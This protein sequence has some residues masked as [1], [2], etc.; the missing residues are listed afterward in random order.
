MI[1]KFPLLFILCYF[2]TACTL[3]PPDNILPVN[4]FEPDRYMGKWYEIARLD[5]SF[6]QGLSDVSAHYQLLPNGDVEVINSGYDVNKKE[7]SNITGLAKFIDRPSVGSLKVSFFWPF[8]GGYH[9]ADL[10]KKN[11]KW[12]IVIGP[13][14]EYLWILARE[15]TLP[16]KLLDQLIKNISKLGIDTDKLIWVSQEQSKKEQ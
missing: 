3:G 12:S 10:D 7:W 15:K 11:Y 8:Y 5:H 14:R 6:E 1:N 2:L 9:I 4:N 13:S 16:T